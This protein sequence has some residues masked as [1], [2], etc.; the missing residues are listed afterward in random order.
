M[1]CVGSCYPFDWLLSAYEVFKRFYGLLCDIAHVQIMV[2]VLSLGIRAYD[3]AVK[4]APFWRLI[5][6]P[7]GLLPK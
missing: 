7:V 3:K 5:N 6:D 2:S 1:V 4:E